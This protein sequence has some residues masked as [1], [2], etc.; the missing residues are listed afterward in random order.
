MGGD[1]T[2]SG[3][4]SSFA[5]GARGMTTVILDSTPLGLLTQR[6]GVHPG[7]TDFRHH[8]GNEQRGTYQ[9]VCAR[10]PLG[11]RVYHAHG[12]DVILLPAVLRRTHNSLHRVIDKRVWCVDGTAEY[13]T[14]AA[15]KPFCE[16]RGNCWRA[17]LAHFA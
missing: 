3:G 13:V 14:E 8:C 12:I 9:P 10:R 16:R 15:D 2:A 7:F 4:Q 11:E 1:E 6:P 17:A 5:P